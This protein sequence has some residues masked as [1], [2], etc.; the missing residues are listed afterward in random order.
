VGFEPTRVK[1][2]GLAGRRLNQL[3]QSDL[4]YLLYMPIWYIGSYTSIKFKA[5]LRHLISFFLSLF[6]LLPCCLAALRL[7]LALII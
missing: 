5:T 1:P 6:A 4:F 2:N 7:S 3:G